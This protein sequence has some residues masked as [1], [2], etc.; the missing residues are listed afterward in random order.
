MLLDFH[1]FCVTCP[2]TVPPIPAT[3]VVVAPKTTDTV[4]PAPQKAPKKVTKKKKKEQVDSEDEDEE[5]DQLDSSEPS[6]EEEE[7]EEDESEEEA[8]PKKKAKTVAKKPV[9]KGKKVVES[10]GK[11]GVKKSTSTKATT[12]AKKEEVPVVKAQT[13]GEFFAQF[14]IDM[15]KAIELAE[16]IKLEF[17]EAEEWILRWYEVSCV[18]FSLPLYSL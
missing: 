12:T 9:A 2:S 10:K 16:E 1:R 7:E 6:E 4:K 13:R 17:E 18:S 5:M 3:P 14:A 15:K 11:K 8:K